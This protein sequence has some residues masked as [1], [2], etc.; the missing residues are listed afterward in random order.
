MILTYPAKR[1]WPGSRLERLGIVGAYGY[2]LVYPIAANDQA[3]IAFA[4]A[5]L[6]MTGWRCVET[7]GPERRARMAALMVAAPFALVLIVG[8]ALRLAGVTTG[9]T[10]LVAYE[11]TVMLI[12]AGLFANLRWG[13][14][15]QATVTALVVDLGDPGTAGTLRDRLARTLADPTLTI[16]YWLSEQNGYVD[17]AGRPV[18]LPPATSSERSH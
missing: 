4:V 5:V 3:T 9:S 18:V 2:A 10:L 16:G 17:E 7:G 13:G 8:P 14:W 11:L 6:A 1:L 12:A 15:A